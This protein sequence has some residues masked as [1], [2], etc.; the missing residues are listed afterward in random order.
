MPEG[1]A[2]NGSVPGDSFDLNAA[3]SALSSSSPPARIAQLRMIDEKLS[4]NGIE[5][6]L[7]KC[8][9]SMQELANLVLQ[10]ALDRAS[11]ASLL[12]VLFWT[13]AFYN[14]R[15]SR[16]AVQRCLASIVRSGDVTM[17]DGLV[18][19]IRQEVQ[20]SGIAISS[21]FV[22]AEWCCLLMQNL[23]GTLLWDK[24]GNDI[25]LAN[26]DALEKCLQPTAKSGLPH[27]ALV[28]AR[29]GLRKLVS[30]PDSRAKT[31]E[32]A[33][34]ILTAKGSQATA[35]NAVLL[36]VIAGVCSRNEDAKP[37]LWRLKSSF[38]TFYA[39]E[40]VGSRTPIP[41][42]IAGGLSDFFASFVTPED[43]E[44]EVF[45]SLEKGLLRA[46]EVVLGLISPLIHSLP[47][48]FDLSKSLSGRLLKPLLSNIKSSNAAIRTGA[49][50]AFK[51]I[52]T[53]CRDFGALEQVADEI[54]GPLKT[55]KLG[56]ADHRVLHSEMLISL[57][58]STVIA[59]KVTGALPAVIAK[60]SNEAALTAET[61]AL[62]TSIINLLPSDADV[63]KAAIDSYVKGMADKKLAFRR[64]WI[65]RAG[66]VLHTFNDDEELPPSLVKFAEAVFPQ[67]LETFNEVISNSLVASQN[68]LVTG[69]LVVCS[70]GS[71]LHRTGSASL[72]ALAKKFPVQKHSLVLDPK[73][74]FLLNPRIYGKFQTDDDFKWLYRALSSLAPAV[75][76][77]GNAAVQSAWAEAYIYLLTSSH[78]SPAMHRDSANSLSDVY[79][80]SGGAV[81]EFI[82]NGLWHWLESLSSG[83][84]ESAAIL[85][86]SDT[87]TLYSVLKAICLTPMDYS[88]RAGADPAKERLEAQMC[89]LLVLARP[90]LIPRAKWIELCLNV[91]L[92]PGDLARKYED[93][94]IDEVV[95]RTGF[96][97]K[98]G[99]A[100]Y[101]VG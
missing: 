12:E 6:M 94:L 61:L 38:F 52:V 67:L 98:V 23:A 86:K 21:A 75:V 40:I 96:E 78:V 36:G 89:S 101:P 20:K 97:Q 41:E 55:G 99:G 62:N 19:K 57:P 56:S 58:P 68:G 7:P 81:V 76:S 59:S 92:D 51:E 17:I 18:L 33:V 79:A 25:I 1:P 5:L 100:R 26:A 11:T 74:S 22:L 65:V 4:Q 66:E 69:A 82:I 16:Q 31:L 80:R 90:E 15:P 87:S 46:P 73:P 85:A 29:R 39:R 47:E 48:D 53:G 42:H 30:I 93:R 71:L 28:L 50:S 27:P 95:A 2:T 3:T 14:D 45:P 10:T 63:P 72:E 49:V 64:I 37:L 34:E 13:H 32:G 77:L 35:K 43:L 70:V 83:E 60:E 24:F 88:A 9:P 84:K 91:G 44:K 8:F 54:L